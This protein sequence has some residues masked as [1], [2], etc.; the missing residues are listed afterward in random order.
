MIRYFQLEVE[1]LRATANCEILKSESVEIL[2]MHISGFPTGQ[3]AQWAKAL[4]NRGGHPKN[5]SET[6]LD[7][8]FWSSGF[9]RMEQHMNA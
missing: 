4:A 2:M 3:T 9:A 7:E 6:R 1:E 8:R 5:L